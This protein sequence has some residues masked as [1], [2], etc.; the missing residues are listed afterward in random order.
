MHPLA[1]HTGEETLAALLVLGGAWSSL[2]VPYSR[3]RLLSVRARLARK[4]APP[5]EVENPGQAAVGRRR[6]RRH[7]MHDLVA[8]Q[9]ERWPTKL[10]DVDV[11]TGRFPPSSALA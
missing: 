7:L 9:G 11:L 4:Q 5:A 2:L 10:D 1:H 6:L 8:I 3:A